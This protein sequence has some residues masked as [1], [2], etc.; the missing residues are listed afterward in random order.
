MLIH[1]KDI[2]ASK[3]QN[4]CL[5]CGTTENINKRKYCSIKCRQNLR[6]KLNARSGLLQALNARYAAFYFSDTMI[7]MDIAPAGFKEIFRFSQERVAGQKPAEE[8]G[9]MANMLGR[10]WWDE[11]QRSKKKYLA[12]RHVLNLAQ[13]HPA[14][15]FIRPKLIKVPSVRSETLNYLGMKKNDLN[16]IELVKIIKNSYRQ[17]A[18]INHPDLGGHASKFRKIHAAYKELLQW[19]ENPRFINRRG[20]SDKWFYDGENKK[21]IQPIPIKK[22]ED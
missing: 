9:K 5:S 6:Q 11:E 1:S 16:S 13:K 10:A 17:Q 21:W 14:V 12:S 8:F 3:N 20:F 4:R 15:T 2:L 19:S 18:K 7:I 22:A